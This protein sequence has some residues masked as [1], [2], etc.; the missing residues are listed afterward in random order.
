MVDPFG[1][2]SVQD[3][4]L[5][6]DSKSDLSKDQDHNKSFKIRCNEDKTPKKAPFR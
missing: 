2:A 4:E 6:P 1:Y 5:S 3:Q